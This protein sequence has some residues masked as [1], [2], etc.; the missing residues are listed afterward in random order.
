MS[1][2]NLKIIFNYTWNATCL[3]AD[4]NYKLKNFQLETYGTKVF[5]CLT[6]HFFTSHPNYSFVTKNFCKKKVFPAQIY[7]LIRISFL[8]VIF[9]Q[10]KIEKINFPQKVYL[11]RVSAH[12]KQGKNRK[13]RKIIFLLNNYVLKHIFFTIPDI[14]STL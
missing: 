7:S 14:V 9:K 12:N 6:W 10:Q 5:V 1:N 13:P 3:I 4:G 2:S 11:C 8:F